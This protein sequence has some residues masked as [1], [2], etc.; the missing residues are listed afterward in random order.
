MARMFF[1]TLVLFLVPGLALADTGAPPMLAPGNPQLFDEL[2]GSWSCMTAAGSAVS[3]NFTVATN[4]DVSEHMDWSNGGSGGAWDQ[5]FS[6]DAPSGT[7]N[8]KNVGSNGMVFTGA[9]HGADGNVVEIT[10]TQTTGA[11]TVPTRE[12]FTFD[13]PKFFSHVWETQ[14]A[15]GTWK[16]TSYAECKRAQASTP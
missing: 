6:Y 2:V 1:A 15:D 10:G 7:W 13:L 11:A 14:S 8:V 16:P 4:G 9:T 3:A 12:R 5:T